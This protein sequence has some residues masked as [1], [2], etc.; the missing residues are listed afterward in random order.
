MGRF[1]AGSAWLHELRWPKPA[2]AA[3]R[4]SRPPRSH[5]SSLGLEHPQNAIRPACREGPTLDVDVIEPPPVPPAQRWLDPPRLLREQRTRA[6]RSPRACRTPAAALVQKAP[7]TAL[8]RAAAPMQVHQAQLRHRRRHRKGGGDVREPQ[9]DDVAQAGRDHE[10]QEQG[11]ARAAD[12][13]AGRDAVRRRHPP[14]G[15]MRNRRLRGKLWA[16]LL[17]DAPCR[18]G[19]P[20]RPVADTDAVRAWTKR[21]LLYVQTTQLTAAESFAHEVIKQVR[22]RLRDACTA[23][24]SFPRKTRRCA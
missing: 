4:Q 13:R 8:G 23:R 9:G 17:G 16:L 3:L 6:G 5:G 20:R 10:A 12:G 22:L 7:K 15:E 14:G 19:A 24:G 21:C 11:A 2:N 1:S 18:F